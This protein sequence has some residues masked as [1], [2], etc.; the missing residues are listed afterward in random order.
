MKLS[1]EG[2]LLQ[3]KKCAMPYN[4]F[5]HDSTISQSFV[6]YIVC[7]Y[8][9]PT[10]LDLIPFIVG[11]QP[12]GGLMKWRGGHHSHDTDRYYSYLHIHDKTDLSLKH[13]IQIPHPMSVFHIVDAFEE[14]KD[15]IVYLKVR[16]AELASKNPPCNRPLL[17][18][19]FA[20]QY[21]V[22]FGT[23]LHS[24][25]K[26]YTFAIQNDGTGVGRFLACR[27]IYCKSGDSIPCDYPITNAVGGSVRLR[28]TWVNT[29]ASLANEGDGQRPPSDWFDAVQKVDIENGALS[30]TPVTFGK[31]V[32]SY[33]HFLK[34]SIILQS[35]LI[36]D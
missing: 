14:E 36:R 3:Q 7:P 9:I 27:N 21:A 8:L 34:M 31:D 35:F 15:E 5:V 32:V 23:R 33:L 25:L 24:T 10:G 6:V 13:R 16:V 18:E 11:Q 20:D 1:P 26:E 22:P 17:E 30:S 19:Q 4:T 12:L 28:Y 2:H 29:I